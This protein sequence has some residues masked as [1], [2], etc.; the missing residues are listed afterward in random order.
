MPFQSVRDHGLPVAQLANL[1]VG[2]T[3]MIGLGGTGKEVLLRLRRLIVERLGNLDALPCIRFLHLDTDKT[4]NALQQYDKNAADDP[5]FEKVGFKPFERI[6]LTVDN[7][8][9]QYLANINAH[10]HI[11]SW[12][13]TKGTMQSIGDRGEGAGQIRMLSRLGFYHKYNN[14]QTALQTTVA[15]LGSPNVAGIVAPLGFMFDPTI[16]NIYVVASLAGGTGSG[17]FLD[18]GFLV[19][20]MFPNSTRVG[21]FFLPS[22]FSGYAAANRMYA[23]GYAALKELNH[24]SFGH[25]FTGNWTNQQI[26]R[27]LPPPF[28]YTY[29]MEGENEE[30]QAIGSAGQEFSMYQMVAE[31]VFQDFSH[32]DFAGM[33][34]A[35]RVN[36]KNFIDNA[37]IHNYWDAAGINV[38]GGQGSVKGDSYTTRFCSFGLSSI[39]FPTER[40][41]RA[42]ACMLA[43]NILDLWQRNAVDDPL[44][45]LFTAFLIHPDIQFVQGQYARR[46][47]GGMI[48][49]SDIED[50]LLMYNREAG[51]TFQAYIWNKSLEI[52]RN[53]E[54]A[55][56]GRKAAALQNSL[57]QWEQLMARADSD[58]PDEW[59]TDIRLIQLNM[60]NY[61]ENLERGIQTNADQFA[62]D[63]RCGISYS[64]SLLGELKK[65]LKNE[66]FRYI[67]F[68]EQSIGGWN[69]QMKKYGDDLDQLKADIA[70]HEREFL[71]RKADLERDMEL[72][73]PRDRRGILYNYFLARIM[74]QVAKRGKQICE[75]IDSFL[76]EDSSGGTGL[77]SRYRQLTANLDILGERLQNKERYFSQ[78]QNYATI[79]SLYQEGDA[80]R[81]YDRWMG[82][83]EQVGQNLKEVSDALLTDIFEV[84][85]VT[86]A[87][88]HIQTEPIEAIEDKII[89]KCRRFFAED[90]PAQ[91]SVLEMLIARQDR[92]FL[93]QTAYM[94][95][96]VWLR[97]TQNV[98]QVNFAIGNGQKPCIIGVDVGDGV[99]FAQFQAIIANIMRP[100]DTPPQFIN[101]G[102]EN[103]G[104]IVFYNE[105]GGATAF[106]PSSVTDVGGLK[107]R[108][109]EFCRNPM[110]ANADNQEDVHIDKNRFQFADIIPKTEAEVRRF[111]DSVRAFVLARLLGVLR[112]R[113]IV[114]DDGV[115][116]INLYS[117]EQHLDYDIV[118][119]HLGDEFAATDIL[120]YDPSPEHESH[121]RRLYDQVETVV[122]ELMN[123]KLLHVYLLLIDF[124]IKQVYLPLLEDSGVAGVQI[125]HHSPFYAALDA[126]RRRVNR[127][128]TPTDE[129]RREVQTALRTLRGRE[130]GEEL[131][132]DEYV[133][134]L[135]P[136][137]S[138]A[139]KFE[140]A[141]QGAIGVRRIFLDVLVLDKNKVFSDAKDKAA[142]EMRETPKP[143]P[144]LP[145]PEAP[146]LTRPCPK[147]GKAIDVR[148]VFCVNCKNIA[149]HI[150]CQHCGET[151]VPDDLKEC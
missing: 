82:P 71:F 107:Q 61:L 110:A 12:F 109:D 101:I 87:L 35:I 38:Q 45:V 148:S 17:T 138:R 64:L 93:I 28:D 11:R 33:K 136:Y 99:R 63:P 36:L 131:A 9:G 84:N 51:E 50:A 62:N 55:S 16:L 150:T 104:S 92:V 43:G 27:I 121:R 13:Q 137:T 57:D 144:S 81:L 21:I 117:Y 142:G 70:D 123:R 46:D 146:K 48:D 97:P 125:R 75:R 2:K 100:G 54:S 77:L 86:Q 135:E 72:L 1:P 14:I 49:R 4:A 127:Q 8:I 42:C 143:R 116:V 20:A 141:A 26:R 124:Y 29:L 68:F 44:D 79:T 31:I 115:T 10:P 103:K 73:V 69:E 3:L 89:E 95:A 133:N 113:N 102:N 40:V 106:Y 96:K 149:E 78:I 59:G 53:T 74:K 105:L 120:Y 98:Q 126:E 114:G 128:L 108:Y 140:F 47:G 122:G 56:D 58:N 111:S 94:R 80:R 52:R 130:I 90:R 23:N 129:D 76:G 151:R 119:V 24:Y 15:T 147:C 41:H 83:A 25:S 85:S 5:L 112:V 7:G 67:P 6:N 18:T 91:P 145:K 39:Y 139:G 32:A 60:N 88:I 34:R 66:N 37:Y 22:F 118:E 30:A 19:K 134:I 65:L 132:Y